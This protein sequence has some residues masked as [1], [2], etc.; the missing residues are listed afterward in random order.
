MVLSSVSAEKRTGK[1]AEYSQDRKNTRLG[2]FRADKPS[3]IIP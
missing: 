3:W 1:K 2:Q